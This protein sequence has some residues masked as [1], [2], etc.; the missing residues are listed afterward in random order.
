MADFDPNSVLERSF[1]CNPKDKSSIFMLKDFRSALKSEY[2]E[3]EDVAKINGK[4]FALCSN[5]S[6]L[7]MIT[8][9]V[10]NAH[11]KYL[12]LDLILYRGSCLYWI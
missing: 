9:S 11:V 2:M 12:C 8:I 5:S 10:N 3:C 1:I 7:M 6:G 4:Y